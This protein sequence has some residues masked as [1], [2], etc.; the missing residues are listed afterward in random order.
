VCVEE[1]R[2]ETILHARVNTSDGGNEPATATHGASS[3][4]SAIVSWLSVF[5]VKSKKYGFLNYLH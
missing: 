2:L 1:C 3:D 5:K 4:K